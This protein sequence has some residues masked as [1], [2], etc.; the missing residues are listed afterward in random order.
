MIVAGSTPSL[1]RISSAPAPRTIRMTPTRGTLVASTR[2]CTKV[3]PRSG[4]SALGEPIRRD[5]PA[6]R[7]AAASMASVAQQ[8]SS[9][10]KLYGFVWQVGRVAPHGNQFGNDTYRDFLR[11]ERAD[12][13]PDGSMHPVKLF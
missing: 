6:A 5:S 10:G 11:T 3:T 7:I 9:L 8:T 12:V 1:A 13:E 4:T 2:C